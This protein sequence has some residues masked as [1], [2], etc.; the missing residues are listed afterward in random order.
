MLL[1]RDSISQLRVATDGVEDGRSLAMGLLALSLRFTRPK[2]S[3]RTLLRAI[4][5]QAAHQNPT[6]SPLEYP[7]L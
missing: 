2:L 7:T 3:T 1:F 5:I 4:R 6:H